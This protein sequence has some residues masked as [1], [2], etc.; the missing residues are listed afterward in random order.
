MSKN[1]KMS[2]LESEDLIE[3]KLKNIKFMEVDKEVG[4]V[5]VSKKKTLKKKIQKI[6]P[7]VLLFQF[8]LVIFWL[9]TYLRFPGII[10]IM[11]NQ[12][13][14]HSNDTSTTIKTTNVIIL[15]VPFTNE[16]NEINETDITKYFDI[17]TTDTLK[18][19]ISGT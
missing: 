8:I 18:L 7:F 5:Y 17:S 14:A 12:K 9:V 10:P 1:E 6:L 13:T 3:Y 16:T 19:N 4:K 2:P 15:V 11:L